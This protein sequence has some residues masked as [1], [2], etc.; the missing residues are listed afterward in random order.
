[1]FTTEDGRAEMIKGKCP[2]S[3]L[4]IHFPFWN[5]SPRSVV[6]VR[7]RFFIFFIFQPIIP[8]ARTVYRIKKSIIPGNINNFI[9]CDESKFSRQVQ[10]YTSFW[11]NIY[12][13]ENRVFN[14][15]CYIT[16]KK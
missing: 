9:F 12:A 4:E 16:M 11:L 10:H 15:L 7:V 8:Y 6:F 5:K 13:Y 14:N 1:M 2:K 3:E